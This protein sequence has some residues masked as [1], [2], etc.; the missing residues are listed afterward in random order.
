MLTNIT[1]NG[2]LVPLS[3]HITNISLGIPQFLPNEY[4]P[5]LAYQLDS[6]DTLDPN[7]Y[8]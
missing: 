5:Q 2:H 3:D 7:D 4:P 8:P 1:K 6:A